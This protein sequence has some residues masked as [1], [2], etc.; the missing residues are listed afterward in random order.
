[1][2]KGKDTVFRR[3][4]KI[5]SPWNISIQSGIRIG[6]YS[7]LAAAPE[8]NPT[9]KPKRVLGARVVATAALQIHARES[10]IVGSDVLIGANVFVSDSS[11]QFRNRNQSIRDQGL[12][13]PRPVV[14]Q[15]GVWIGQNCVILPGVTIG[16]NAVIAANSVVVSDIPPFSLAAGAP[17]VIK[18]T[19]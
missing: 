12:T 9:G 15:S 14:I 17:A 4:I 5:E 1:M 19:F 18:K 10:I 11:H 16:Q 8:I 13:V 2:E 7:L 6:P 3:P